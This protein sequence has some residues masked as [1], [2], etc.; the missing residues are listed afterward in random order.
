[1]KF[2]NK[3][4][5]I[6]GA[7][8]G[9]GLLTSQTFVKEGGNVV[10][11]GSRP[12]ALE[13]AVATVNA[14]RPGSAIGV[15]CDAREYDQVCKVCD[16]A[17]ETFGSL[18][19][20]V[21]YA[22][23]AELRML[24]DYISSLNLPSREFPDIPIDVYDWG[25]DVNLKGQFYFDHAACKHMRAQK[26][27]V[28]INIGSIAGH[29]GTASNVAYATAKSA[30]MNGLV[31]SVAQYGGAYGIRC[32]CV[33]PGPVLTRANM[34]NM[35]TLVGRAAEPQEVVDLV[36]YLASDEGSF[37]NGVTLLMD[38]GRS[39]MLNKQ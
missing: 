15:V 3:T 31:K 17:I 14:I 38:G 2:A 27:G 25:L 18:D 28:I 1:M 34:A 19:V 9:L 11:T 30:V 36:L 5:V 35:K 24:S 21:T 16:A 37:F 39:I 33:A 26:S 7:S 20:L 32:C 12:Q 4:A 6:S 29:D 13:E 23:G 8:L 22:G 10:M